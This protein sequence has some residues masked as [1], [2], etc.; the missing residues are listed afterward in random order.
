MTLY[1]RGGG[2]CVWI[3]VF[4]PDAQRTSLDGNLHHSRRCMQMRAGIMSKRACER[5][6]HTL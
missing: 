1:R 6:T 5:S 4:G 2:V 3:R